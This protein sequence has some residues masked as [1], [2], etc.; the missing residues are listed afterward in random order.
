MNL[1]DFLNA[2]ARDP[3]KQLD[4]EEDPAGFAVR[5]GLSVEEAA[6]VATRDPVRLRSLLARGKVERVADAPGS[7]YIYTP[8]AAIIYSPE[9]AMIY[10]PESAF[11]YTAQ[12]RSAA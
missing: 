2:L 3:G 6:V 10:S 4:F 8:E 12:T 9:S 1:L 7:A 5:S 11:V